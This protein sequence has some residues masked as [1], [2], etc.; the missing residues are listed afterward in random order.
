MQNV[1]IREVDPI[2]ARRAMEFLAETIGQELQETYTSQEAAQFFSQL[3][4]VC[5]PGTIY[6]LIRKRYFAPSN[7]NALNICDLYCIGHIL[8]SRR[9]WKPTPSKH[10]P[11][12]TGIRLRIEQAQAEG[13]EPFADA[14][15][16]TVEDAL[17]QIVQ[18]DSRAQREILYELL[19]H[20]LEGCEE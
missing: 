19:R 13:V 9:R 16:I 3:D 8:E 5:A 15:G 1:R 6:E 11:K 7:P 18:S 4:Y 2:E 17:I 20:K 12:K 14:E 10:D